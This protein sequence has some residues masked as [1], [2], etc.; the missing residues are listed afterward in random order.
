MDTINR[1]V[2]AL[3]LLMFSAAG[4]AEWSEIEKFE[5]GMLVFVDPGSVRRTGDTARVTH[6]VR[7]AE[8]Q[9]EPGQPPYL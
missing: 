8:P 2:L 3:F 4:Y 9:R 7:W 6:L 1:V 5:D